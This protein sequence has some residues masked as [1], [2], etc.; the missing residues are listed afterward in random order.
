MQ[1]EFIKEI[2]IAVLESV[3]EKKSKDVAPI[4]MLMS[5]SHGAVM[6]V[7]KD[8]DN[9][10]KTAM[11]IITTA[12]VLGDVEAIMFMTE[13]WQV[14]ISDP[15]IIKRFGGD[16]MKIN[17]WLKSK[18][19]SLGDCP[20]RKESLMVMLDDG[21]NQYFIT[22]E[23]SRDNYKFLEWPKF[24]K[25]FWEPQPEMKIQWQ[26]TFN[27]LMRKSNVLHESLEVAK[28]LPVAFR[29]SAERI[30]EMALSVLMKK[31][32]YQENAKE[33]AE[34]CVALG[35]TIIKRTQGNLSETDKKTV[36]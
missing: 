22:H 11:D 25:D 34:R 29:P 24:N 28:V 17:H 35:K 26:T 5:K 16:Q 8:L 19:P 21:V 9:K 3:L 23:M 33:I 36:H 32:G 7:F 18:W 14:E 27:D 20:F 4:A 13:S 6:M 15:K 30:V 10:T 2:S 12:A 1:K 31:I